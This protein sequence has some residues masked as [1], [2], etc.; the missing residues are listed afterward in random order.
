MYGTTYGDMAATP[1]D[2]AWQMLR[3]LRHSPPG[4]AA[5]GPR[6]ARFDA[7]LE[8]SEQLFTAAGGVGPETR[9]LL[10]FYG[11][12]QAGRAIAA[13][14]TA[15][16]SGDW[17]LT[18]HGIRASRLEVA[19]S[20]GLAAAAV[21]DN[22]DGSF[23]RVAG[24]L[25][26][27]SLPAATPLGALWPLLPELHRFPLPGAAAA[28][29]LSVTPDRS[30]RDG[31]TGLARVR[32]RPL[33]AS[34]AAPPTGDQSDWDA[35][36]RD[37][38]AERQAVRAFLTDYPG[39]ADAQFVTAQ[40]NPVGLTGDGSGALAADLDVPVAGRALDDRTVESRSELWAY[41]S[42]HAKGRAQH[43]LTVWW[44][45][46]YALSMFARYY[47]RVWAGQASVSR[48]AD[49]AAIEHL[50]SQ[51]LVALPEL[52]HRTIMQAAG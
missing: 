36:L 20:A 6:K 16:G 14:S 33:P 11:L 17:E 34:V 31:A 45:V 49:A 26:A 37:W 10:V 28:V 42:L 51:S 27:E 4:R 48:S 46:T 12:S 8:Q 22:G 39:L 47:P 9:P 19:G 41:P 13:A 40:G 38:P 30:G 2:R 18:G 21:A 25:G 5:R 7:A 32:V 24:L 52:V 15:A 1:P 50:L 43:P 44:A 29:P 3:S 23:T 35:S